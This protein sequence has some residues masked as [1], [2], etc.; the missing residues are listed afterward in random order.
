MEGKRMVVY[1][2]LPWKRSGMVEVPWK[3][4]TYFLARDV[5]AS[6]LVSF[7]EKEI[8]Q[9]AGT[10]ST[11][12]ALETPHFSVVFDLKKGGISSLIE[13]KS[14]KELIDT[15]QG[16][17]AGQFL[18][19][20]FS[21]NEVGAW[22][23]QYSRIKEGWGLNDLGKPGM[24]DAAQV[25]YLASTPQN[26]HV[27]IASSDVADV[28]TLTPTDT[29]GLAKGYQIVFS[30]PR[31]E[32]YMDVEW[33]VDSK[34]PEKHPEG[35]WLCFPLAVKEPV[36]T[37]GRLGGT[38]DPSKDIV[39]GTNRYLMAVSSG[40]AVTGADGSGVGLSPIDSPL[41]S[42]G[43]PG[44]WKYSENDIPRKAA[45][46]VNLY[47][48]MWNTNFPLWQD[49]SW[50]EKVRIWGIDGK[51]KT[52]QDLVRN[53]WEARLPL[54]TGAA[55]GP[56]GHLPTRQEGL[57][58]SRKGALVTAFGDNPDGVGIVLRLW[59]Q[60]GEAGNITVSFPEKS[61]FAKATPVNLRG[62]VVG[63]PFSVTDNKLRFSLGAYQPASF[64]LE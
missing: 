57:S 55:D 33:V 4:G 14:G 54:L 64:L 27:N 11:F 16:Y 37:V 51:M 10:A 12:S 44:L 40:V 23:N 47:N 34:T 7:S 25:P 28:A 32:G 18:H 38:I 46:F 26:W 56:K 58:V 42:L 1:N 5:P 36:F 62:E 22:F 52:N 6:G 45:V 20:R 24:A 39:A 15:S 3:K 8:G 35:G 31:H 60:A 63:K 59:E 61:K 29:R 41:I 30:F 2:P 21:S 17:V 53:A 49:G 50:S 9:A 43:E 19:E 13:K 48:N